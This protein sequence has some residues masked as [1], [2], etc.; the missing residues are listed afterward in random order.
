M[1]SMATTR[2]V[3]ILLEQLLIRTP[4]SMHRKTLVI[5]PSLGAGLSPSGD[6]RLTKKFV[7]GMSM[8]CSHWDGPV[9]LLVEHDEAPDSGNLDDIWIAPDEL[10]FRVTV[11]DFHS[12]QAKALIARAAVVQGGTDHRLNHMP[13]WCAELGAQYVVVSE[14]TLRTRWQIIDAEPLNPL[15]NWRR[16]LWAWRQELANV[17]AVKSAAAVQCNGTPTF[18]VYSRLNTHALLY[19]DS[20]VTTDMLPAAPRLARRETPWSATDPIRLAFSGR[21]N[22][23]KGADHLPLVAKALRDR[24]VPFTMDI[25]GEG[26]LVNE[27]KKIIAHHGLQ[28]VVR[29]GGVLD[30][31]SELMP[32]VRDEVDLFV[33]CHRQGDPSCTY[34]ETW[35]CGVPIVGYDNEAF[36]GMMQRCPAG[37]SVPMNDWS[38]MAATIERMV[39]EPRRLSDM[40]QLGLAFS[41]EHTFELEFERRMEHL[42]HLLP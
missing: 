14:Y 19:F 41:R 36:T 18:D 38:A 30:F 16:K 34:L 25:Y 26:P 21:L 1:G 3:N 32:K 2:R 20:R 7:S 29:L 35:A 40:A 13:G 28:D 11:A 33:C 10:P 42:A 39:R 31:T 9:E 4:L 8:I 27:L 5:V 15:I 37:E 23:M 24:Q 6:I 22:R 12:P 17:A